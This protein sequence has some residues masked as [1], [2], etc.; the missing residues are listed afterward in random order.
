[1]KMVDEE[2][3]SDL[4]KE[5]RELLAKATPG[6]WSLTN[7]GTYIRPD[8]LRNTKPLVD[9]AKGMPAWPAICSVTPWPQ[10]RWNV[11]GIEE[12]LGNAVLIARAPELLS[13]LCDEVEELRRRNETQEESIT[14]LQSQQRVMKEAIEAAA[15]YIKVDPVLDDDGLA[16]M[17][18]LNAAI[19]P[20]GSEK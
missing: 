14:H 3:K 12:S 5:A 4:V 15:S 17:A 19:T 8:C 9:P 1:M 6:S 16:A 13:A 20:K 18:Q 10:D 7:D 2:S 11:L